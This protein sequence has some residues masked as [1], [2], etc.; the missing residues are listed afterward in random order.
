MERVVR[1][2]RVDG[3]EV[4]IV[5]SIEEDGSSIRLVVDDQ[6]IN[7]DAP[8]AGPPSD[9]EI[10]AAVARLDMV[11][12]RRKAADLGMGAHVGQG[13]LL[14][15]TPF[16]RPECFDDGVERGGGHH[17]TTGLVNGCPSARRSPLWRHAS[18]RRERTS[19]IGSLLT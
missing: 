8:L 12:A 18:R 10:C 19:V 11:G 3:H 1:T 16:E 5:E 4:A 7:P 6:V 15:V 14:E 17:A 13:D 9:R 2:L